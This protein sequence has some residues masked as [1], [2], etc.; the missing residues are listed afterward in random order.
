MLRS[1]PSWIVIRSVLP[2][3]YEEI[4]NRNRTKIVNQK[5]YRRRYSIPQGIV[6]LDHGLWTIP[7][8]WV[9]IWLARELST[10]TRKMNEIMT[11]LEI[12]KI[13]ENELLPPTSKTPQVN[14]LSLHWICCYT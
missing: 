7:N 10:L 1:R 12:T 8:F 11:K 3:C 5:I 13:V 14:Y 6:S 9:L 4:V 2:V